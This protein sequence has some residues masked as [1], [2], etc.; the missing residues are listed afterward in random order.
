M[1][2]KSTL[3]IDYSVKGEEY[4]AQQAEL[5]KNKQPPA[6]TFWTAAFRHLGPAVEA[7]QSET[8]EKAQ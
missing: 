4:K 3:A 8:K 1:S 2:P 5:R 7:L 6:K